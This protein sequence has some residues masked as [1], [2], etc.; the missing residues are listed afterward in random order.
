MRKGDVAL[1]RQRCRN[2]CRIGD[3]DLAGKILTDIESW[4]AVDETFALYEGVLREWT[5]RI[6]MSKHAIGKVVAVDFFAERLQ[7]LVPRSANEGQLYR[8]S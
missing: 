1:G 8:P 3:G 7:P 5:F 4:R 2:E 6:T